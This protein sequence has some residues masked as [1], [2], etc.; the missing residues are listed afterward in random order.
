MSVPLQG[1]AN[2]FPPLERPC[3]NCPLPRNAPVAPDSRTVIGQGLQ[4]SGMFWSLR[5]A[6]IALRCGQLSGRFDA[7]RDNAAGKPAFLSWPPYEECAE[8]SLIPKKMA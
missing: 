3:A 2:R 7:F 6:M 8:G 4:H 5:G 1:R